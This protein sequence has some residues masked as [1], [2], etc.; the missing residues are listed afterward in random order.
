MRVGRS[1][2]KMEKK[3]KITKTHKKETYDFLC[4]SKVE[5]ERNEIDDVCG[6]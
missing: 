6:N 5:W 2:E 3:K 1:P 4:R